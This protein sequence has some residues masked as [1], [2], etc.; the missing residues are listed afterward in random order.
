[1]E[2][3]KI[4][5]DILSKYKIGN[6]DFDFEENYGEKHR[7]YHT[8]EHIYSM[9]ENIKT[10]PGIVKNSR[11]YDILVIAIVFHDIIYNVISGSK[12][13]EDS[14][15]YFLKHS[16]DS[17]LEDNEK[18]QI[19]E[20]I[21]DT[22]HQAQP[23]NKLGTI[24]CKL[25][26][27]NL[28]YGSIQQ[29]LSDEYKI[30]KEY[31]RFDYKDYKKGR[32]EFF[33]M[34][35]KLHP[36]LDNIKILTE[37]VKFRQPKIA[38]YPGSFNPFHKGHLNILEKAEQIFDKVIIA[39]GIN[40]DKGLPSYIF[41][42]SL[43]FRQTETYDGLLTDFIQKLEYTV[44]VIRG[45]RNTTDLQYELTQYRFLQD[46][47]P[48]IKVVSIFCDS[49]YEHISSSSIRQLKEFKAEHRYLVK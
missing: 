49:E 41:P 7:F 6:P 46:L 22:K 17:T 29:V 2:A 10:F 31:Q 38:L 27:Q 39:R 24:L 8:L 35:S 45:L 11:E 33:D 30:F 5:Y 20:A 18:V 40:L 23:L 14:A 15:N 44:T 36:N 21:L 4:V 42:E 19:V 48:D 37:Y 34:F 13:E 3:E 43:S 1:M 25:D 9:I 32:L 47:N 28:R 12:N 26:L 16:I